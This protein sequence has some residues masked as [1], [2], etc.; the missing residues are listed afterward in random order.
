MS[1]AK[2]EADALNTVRR[3]PAAVQF[4]RSLLLTILLVLMDASRRIESRVLVLS[5]V[6]PA[7]LSCAQRRIVQHTSASW[8]LSEKK[9]DFLSFYVLDL[10]PLLVRHGKLYK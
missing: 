5:Q 1:R 8:K 9:E 7:P 6:L 10:E 4:V 2:H 3:A